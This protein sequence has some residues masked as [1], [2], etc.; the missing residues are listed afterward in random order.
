MLVT[1]YFQGKTHHN[2]PWQKYK[3]ICV[4]RCE[5]LLLSSRTWKRVSRPLS[6]Y[7]CFAVS[8]QKSLNIT[9]SI[10][11]MS[12]WGPKI[13]RISVSKSQEVPED[14]RFLFVRIFLRIEHA[15]LGC[16]SIHQNG[17]K[18]PNYRIGENWRIVGWQLATLSLSP[19]FL[20]LLAH[21]RSRSW[22]WMN[23]L[24]I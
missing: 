21:K 20:S 8:Q 6:K 9:F 2:M 17:S 22:Q 14:L 15:Y 24:I 10:W 5:L 18:W 1:V 11:A 7:Y 16:G 13:N 3:W 4:Y 19:N 12:E 23:E